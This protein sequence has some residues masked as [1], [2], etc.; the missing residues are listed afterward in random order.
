VL[1]SSTFG[2]SA[3]VVAADAAGNHVVVWTAQE[4]GGADTSGAG[5]YAQRYTASGE[6]VGGRFLVNTLTEGTQDMPSVAMAPSGECVIAWYDRTTRGIHARSFDASGAARGPAFRVDH[7]GDTWGLGARIAMDG[8]GAV[9][10]M[11][12]VRRGGEVDSYARRY[13]AT[14]AELGDPFLLPTPAGA[15]VATAAA[16]NMLVVWETLAGDGSQDVVARRL[17]AACVPSGPEFLVNT[18]T[19]GAQAFSSVTM[20]QAGEAVILWY[21][22][23]YF[24]SES[25]TAVQALFAQRFD[26]A[27]RRRG[28]VAVVSTGA[29]G[30]SV[31]MDD[32]GNY[33]VAW[34]SNNGQVRARKFTAGGSPAGPL[35]VVTDPGFTYSLARASVAADADGDFVVAYEARRPLPSPSGTYIRRY[36]A[37]PVALAHRFDPAGAPAQRLIV[38][39]SEDVEASL[40]AGDLT[41]TNRTTGETVLPEWTAFQY[42]AGEHTATFTFPGYPGGVLPNGDYRATVRA[43]DVSDAAGNALAGDYSGDFFALAGD[44]N[45]DRAVNGS[46]FALLAANFGKTGRSYAQGDLTGD[47]AVNGTDFAILA[48]NF[49]RLLQPPAAQ[50]ASVT[51]AATPTG[52]GPAAKRQPRRPSPR[53]P[54]KLKRQSFRGAAPGGAPVPPM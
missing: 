24:T 22:D 42:N 12:G 39:F 8:A 32:A 10:L 43:A 23:G 7:L 41:L 48:G 46:D 26:A 44:V 47:G 52:A 50:S 51:S 36:T 21:G 35:V 20:N 49:G 40:A 16:G 13:S 15:A 45:R 27:G 28:E 17:D 34:P 53:K 37:S 25:G 31:A 2:I 54:V 33:V 9:L 3:V 38:R 14:G 19:R 5:I 29:V 11:W 6:P 4:P 1:F 18:Y 30:G